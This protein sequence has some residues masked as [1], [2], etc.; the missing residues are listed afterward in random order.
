MRRHALIADSPVRCSSCQRN[1][2]GSIVSPGPTIATS[3]SLGN[4]VLCLATIGSVLWCILSGAI[5]L[6]LIASSRSRAQRGA[7]LSL[8]LDRSQLSL[9]PAMMADPLP[10]AYIAGRTAFQLPTP[11]PSPSS[12]NAPCTPTT[13]CN[14]GSQTSAAIGPIS[15]NTGLPDALSHIPIDYIIDRLRSMAQYYWHRP[16]TTNCT[17]SKEKIQKCGALCSEPRC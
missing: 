15:P 3:R 6:Q 2:C 5:S 13:P 7:P 17:I 9:V 10:P 11:G 14:N 8:S 4:K 12:P 1:G 16:E